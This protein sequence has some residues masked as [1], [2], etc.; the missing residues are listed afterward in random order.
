MKHQGSRNV[1]VRVQVKWLVLRLALRKLFGPM[2]FEIDCVDQDHRGVSAQNSGREY[3]RYLVA[4]LLIHPLI[5]F[6]TRLLGI[7]LEISLV[8]LGPIVALKQLKE[9]CP[10]RNP[11]P[12]PQRV[13]DL[14][15]VHLL[16]VHSPAVV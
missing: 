8:N 6:D 15:R 13:S 16:A 4:G 10:I 5:D 14:H 11:L 2:A 12:S 9:T 3:G 1:L 7:I